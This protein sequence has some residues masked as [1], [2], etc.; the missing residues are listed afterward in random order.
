MDSYVKFLSKYRTRKY[1]KGEV[2]LYQDEVPSAAYSVKNGIVKTYNITTHGEEK[3]I[4][5]SLKHEMFP[6]GWIFFKLHRAQYFY[7]AF[8]DCELYIIPRSDYLKFLA[9]NPS[10]LYG[11]FDQFV[12][13]YISY[14]MHVNAL[15]QSKAAEKVLSTL[16]TLAKQ[17]GKYLDDDKIKI[18]LPLTQQDLANFMGLTRET[19]GLELKKLERKGIIIHSNH[20]YTVRSKQLAKLLGDEYTPH[21]AK[22]TNKL[23][24]PWPKRVP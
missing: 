11:L 4:T 5:F 7:E 13:R 12:G 15:E 14:Q 3:P 10:S 19:T 21:L 22:V 17:Y 16:D 2:I 24:I 8:T 1:S 6:I 23:K 9:K 18:D 20:T